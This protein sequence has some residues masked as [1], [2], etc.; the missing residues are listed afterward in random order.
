MKSLPALA[1]SFAIAAISCAVA[2]R[3]SGTT[4]DNDGVLHEP[5]ALIPIGYLMGAGAIATASAAV[6]RQGRGQKRSGPQR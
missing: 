6:L 5:F 4:V 1:A 2:Y 3:V